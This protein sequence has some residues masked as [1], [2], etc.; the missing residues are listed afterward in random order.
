M[1]TNNGEPVALRA[2]VR[3]VFFT[4]GSPRTNIIFQRDS[5]GRVEGYISRREERDLR[6]SKIQPSVRASRTS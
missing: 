5:Q 1:S 6:F 4:P 2:A 3:D